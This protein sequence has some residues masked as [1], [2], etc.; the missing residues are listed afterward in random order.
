MVAVVLV[1]FTSN[2][3]EARRNHQRKGREN[4][5]LRMYDNICNKIP[6]MLELSPDQAKKFDKIRKEHREE[7]KELMKKLQD[8]KKEFSKDLNEILTPDQQE[9]LKKMRNQMRKGMRR[10]WRGGK[11]MGRGGQNFMPPRLMV[12]ALRKMNLDDE[13]V[14]KIKDIVGEMR[15]RVRQAGRGNREEIRKIITEATKEI[16]EVLSPEEFKQLKKIVNEMRQEPRGN[17]GGRGYGDMQRRG[18]RRGNHRGWNEGNGQR[19]WNRGG[20]G[21]MRGGRDHSWRGGWDRDK[22]DFHP[23]P[24]P[25]REETNDNGFLW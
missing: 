5:M 8:Q 11:R 25:P 23:V 4:P 3:A 13:Q 10:A 2:L 20:N 18:G 6:D 16:K 12:Q 15:D 17:R 21:D 24:P 22:R 1:F 14:G 9:Q 7:I 19:R